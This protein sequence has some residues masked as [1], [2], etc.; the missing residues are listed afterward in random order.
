MLGT[1][2]FSV[3]SIAFA[4]FLAFL[5]PLKYSSQPEESTMFMG[6]DFCD[7][8]GLELSVC[9]TGDFGVYSW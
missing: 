2:K 3:S 8:L 1:S 4:N 9:F 6:S 5:E 7:F